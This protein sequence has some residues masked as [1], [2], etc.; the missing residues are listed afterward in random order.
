MGLRRVA[1]LV[2]A[3]CLAKCATST[4]CMV[5]DTKAP[6]GLAP[7]DTPQFIVLTND[8]A[9]TVITQPIIFNITERHTNR[10]GCKMPAT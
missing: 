10:N 4:S 3:E 7:E 2:C 1:L 5:P 6:G 9:I 8:D